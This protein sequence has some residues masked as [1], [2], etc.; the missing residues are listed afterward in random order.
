MQ[1]WFN[2]RW[3][4]PQPGACRTL[5]PLEW[6]YGAG[7]ALRRARAPAPSA[8]AA[9]VIIVGN[10]TVG[11]TGKTPL[12]VWLARQLRQRGLEVGLISRGYGRRDGGV[13]LLDAQADWREVGDE[14]LILARASGCPTAVGRDRVAAARAVLARG[15]RVIVSDDG[16]QHLALPR[17]CS[18]VV[19]DG[20]RGFGNGRLLPGGPLREPLSRLAQA[21]ALVINGAAEHP[22]LGASAAHFPPR[23][24]RMDLQAGPAV[25]LGSLERRALE[26]F[27]GGP[28]HAVAGIGHPQRFFRELRAHGLELIEHPFPDHHPLRAQELDFG[29]DR[30]VLMTEKDAV[31]CGPPFDRRLWWVPVEVVLSGADAARLI[32]LSL[33]TIGSFARPPGG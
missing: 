27:R 8:L 25:A 1:A 20:A 29:D 11:G 5:R 16:L 17:A 21:D 24:V 32:E 2:R 31:K 7:V 10:L 30:P 15:A 13:R 6:L 22:S 3:Y 14:P 18:I 4:G 26:A 12:T 28:V 9:P 23:V 33:R 19:V